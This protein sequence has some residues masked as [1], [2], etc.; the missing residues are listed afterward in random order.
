MYSGTTQ[1]RINVGNSF[2]AEAAA[3]GQEAQTYA[4]EVNA[5]IAQ[6]G[7][8]GQVAG[9]YINAAQGFASELN[10]KIAISQGYGNEMQMRMANL[11]QE[12]QWY[13]AR[14]QELKYDYSQAFGIARPPAQRQ[15]G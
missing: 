1:N 11:S 10:S 4:N 3:S 2:L 6:V 12:Y 14:Y 8:Y 15:E 13:N 7:G 9:A 5:R